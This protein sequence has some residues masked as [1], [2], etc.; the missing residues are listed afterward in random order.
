MM[1]TRL[2]LLVAQNQTQVGV[3]LGRNNPPGIV[4]WC[5]QR[6]LARPRSQSLKP[7]C[8]DVKAFRRDR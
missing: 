7:A 2:R 3:E 1:P 5:N 8:G 6:Q 4:N